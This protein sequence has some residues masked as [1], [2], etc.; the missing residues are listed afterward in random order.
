MPEDVD[1]SEGTNKDSEFR[2]EFRGNVQT[3]DVKIGFIT[4]DP[5]NVYE[6]RK[7][8]IKLIDKEMDVVHNYVPYALPLFK[9]EA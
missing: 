4:Q 1:D 2:N 6:S 5:S 8:E 9:L 3:R 7:E